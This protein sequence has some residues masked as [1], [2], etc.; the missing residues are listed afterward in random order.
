VTDVDES[1]E[2]DDVAMIA[3]LNNLEVTRRSEDGRAIISDDE[4]LES[5]LRE[6]HEHEGANALYE[7]VRTCIVA[8]KLREKCKEFVAKC[9]SCN[10]AKETKNAMTASGE[11]LEVKDRSSEPWEYIHMDIAGP[12]CVKDGKSSMYAI[13]LIDNFSSYAM[14]RTTLRCPTA[15][16]CVALYRNVLNVFNTCP[17]ICHTDNG[18]HFTCADW[19]AELSESHCHQVRSPREASYC[20]GKVERLHRIINEKL[21]AFTDGKMSYVMFND[22]VRRAIQCHNTATIA[23][24]GISPHEVIFHFDAWIHPK[25]PLSLRPNFRA[26]CTEEDETISSR[27]ELPKVGEVWL[28]RKFSAEK[29]SK[30]S[31]PYKPCLILKC[32]SKF[33]YRAKLVNDGRIDD[34]VVHLRRMKKIERRLQNQFRELLGDVRKEIEDEAIGAT[35]LVMGEM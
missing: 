4:V 13:T 15:K 16:D 35:D 30:I 21:R 26:L 7:R 17:K 32:I 19:V 24:K 29:K 31:R 11:K 20:N 18:S 8:A 1:E 14:A 25:V 28:V 9:A 33:L 6:I 22:I 10:L 3:A 12:Y 34:R 27:V 5:F 2:P 23:R